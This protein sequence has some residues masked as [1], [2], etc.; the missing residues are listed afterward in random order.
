[1]KYAYAILSTLALTIFTGCATFSDPN[2]VTI[3][4]IHG[5]AMTGTILAVQEHPE[6]LPAFKVAHDE[7]GVLVKNGNLDFSQVESIIQR[8]PV[9]ELHGSEA[10]LIITAAG[11]LLDDYVRGLTDL[12]KSA[13][14]QTIAQA[15]Y[16][17][18]DRALAGMGS[19]SL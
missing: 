12:K 8:L 16:D 13:A 3:R 5:A 15:I 18:L 9:N 2:S 17:G 14:A 19:G 11:V 10:R 6:W 7:L 4:A 1:M